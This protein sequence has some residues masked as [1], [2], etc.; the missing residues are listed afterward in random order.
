MIMDQDEAHLLFIILLDLPNLP[1][2]FE[3]H[4]LQLWTSGGEFLYDEIHSFWRM[5]K[6]RV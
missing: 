6:L 3:E 1:D 5:M 4:G 2:R